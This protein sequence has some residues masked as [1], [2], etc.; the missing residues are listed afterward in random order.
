MCNSCVKINMSKIKILISKFKDILSKPEY[1]GDTV[2][3][4]TRKESYK[5]K[6][7][8]ANPKE[9]WKI[10]KDTHEAIVIP[11]PS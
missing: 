1:A 11:T 5:D 10:F 7:S 3:F 4:R 9:N 8:V 2:N 6:Q